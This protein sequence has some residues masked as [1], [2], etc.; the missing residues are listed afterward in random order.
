MQWTE[1]VTLLATILVAGWFSALITQTLKQQKW[2]SSAKLILSA[3]VAAAVAI[4][5]AWLSGDV[6]HFVT[7]YKTGGLTAAEVMTFFTLVFS[8]GATWYRFYFRDAEWAQNL[9]LWPQKTS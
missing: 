1:I 5:A 3:V 9:A 2:P 4:A 7:I 6:L 8:S